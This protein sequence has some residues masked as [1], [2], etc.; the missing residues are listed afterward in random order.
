MFEDKVAR[1]DVEEGFSKSDVIIEGEFEVG[2]AFHW[3]ME[4][5]SAYAIPREDG[6]ILVQGTTQGAGSAQ[7]AISKAL[8]IPLKDVTVQVKRL[9]GSF[10]GKGTRQHT[11]IAAAVASW[12]TGRPVKLTLDRVTDMLSTGTNAPHFFQYKAGATKDGKI[13]AVKVKAF[14]NGGSAMDFSLGMIGETLKHIDNCYYIPHFQCEGR[15]AKTNIAPTK[16]YRG[17][18]IPQGIVI[19]EWLMDHMARKLGMLLISSV[20]STSTR[21]GI[22]HLSHKCLIM[23]P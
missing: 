23:L 3:Y 12:T 7:E 4:P 16:P 18:G 17:A 22:P 11:L 9:G 21:M 15:V 19:S 14:A 13:Q 1:G 20:K 2:G 8:G 10:G 5:Q 6:G